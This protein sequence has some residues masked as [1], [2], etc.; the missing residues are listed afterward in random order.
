MEYNNEPVPDNEM[1]RLLTL[2]EFDLDYSDLKES[3][4]DLTLLAAKVA[5]TQISLINLIDSFTLWSLSSFGID[6][7]QVPREESVCQHTIMTG[8]PFE[9]RDLRLDQRFNTNEAVSGP[10]GLRYYYGVPLKV[11]KGI[12]IG[13]LCVID[14]DLKSM[15]PEKVEMLEIIAG[16]VVKRLKYFRTINQMKA[17]L[18]EVEESKKKVAHDIRGP[19]SGIIG[20]SEIMATHD[21]TK[22]CE[23]L[24]E[25]ITMINNSSTSLLELAD[26]ILTDG[27]KTHLQTDEFNLSLFKKKLEH[28]YCSQANY[29]DLKLNIAVEPEHAEIFLSKDKLMQIAGNLISNAIKFTPAKGEINVWLELKV[30]DDKKLLKIEVRDNG[31]G[32]DTTQIAQILTGDA[33]TNAGT[34]GEKGYGFGLNLVVHLV[35]MLK[36]QLT[37]DSIPGKGT[38][39]SVW[40]PQLKV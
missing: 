24:N 17:Q 1:E 16:N 14:S 27:K 19:I 31:V 18:R 34:S 5:G 2:S 6:L 40:L 20:L 4:K 22:N 30:S 7:E 11:E 37:I 38:T 26:E 35:E 10:L 21:L 23:E 13:S 33:V 28:L 8:Q 32:I 25:F 15:T 3:F 9:I 39:F 12:H 36:G 29:K